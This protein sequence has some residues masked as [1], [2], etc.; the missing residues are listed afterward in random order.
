MELEFIRKQNLVGKIWEYTFTKPAAFSYDAGDYVELGIPN[1]GTHW[2]SMA[3]APEEDKLLFTV[4]IRDQLSG[5]KAAL[6]NMQPG[7]TVV[8]SPAIGNFNLPKPGQKALFTALGI[9]ITPYR[10]LLNTNADHSNNT[11]LYIARDNEHVYEDVIAQSGVNY[12]KHNARFELHEL[13]SLVPDYKEHIVYLSGP[14]AACM[15]IY[16]RLVESGFERTRIK[17]EYFPGY[18]KI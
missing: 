16:T 7:D 11:L 2:L 17:L 9:G 4:K 10:S 12:V 14:Q 6:Q 18:L 3:S 8:S 1:V 13:E 15:D 5:F